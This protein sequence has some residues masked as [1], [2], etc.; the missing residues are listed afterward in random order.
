MRT[1]GIVVQRRENDM[2]LKGTGGECLRPMSH[3]DGRHL[4]KNPE[5]DYYTWEDDYD[6]GCC[7]PEEIDRCFV[8][9]RVSE[10]EA[11]CLMREA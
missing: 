2:G 7:A 10:E 6:C 11:Q 8:Y 1:C 3:T 9:G 5:G 4:F